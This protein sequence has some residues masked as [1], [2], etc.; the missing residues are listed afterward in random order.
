MLADHPARMPSMILQC[1][2]SPVWLL[3]RLLSVRHRDH[4]QQKQTHGMEALSPFFNQSFT[5]FSVCA[6]KI[7][8]ASRGVA[9]VVFI[10]RDYHE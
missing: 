2:I 5:L 1:N 6:S 7:K 4:D 3:C 9:E 8:N 10:K